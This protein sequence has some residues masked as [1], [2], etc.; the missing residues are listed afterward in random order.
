MIPGLLL[1]RSCA[2]CSALDADPVS[3]V[4]EKGNGAVQARA[5]FKIH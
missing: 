1:A 4:K 2:V 3:F 5:G